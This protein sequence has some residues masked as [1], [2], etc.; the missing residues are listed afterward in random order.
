MIRAKKQYQ[1][2]AVT[3]YCQQYTVVINYQNTKVSWAAESVRAS[4]HSE[5]KK[6]NTITHRNCMQLL[7]YSQE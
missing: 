3:L 4:L 7:T 5:E 1:R 6:Q 2:C